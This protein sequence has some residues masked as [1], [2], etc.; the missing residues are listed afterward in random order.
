MKY[1]DI[2]FNL[3]QLMAKTCNKLDKLVYLRKDEDGYYIEYAFLKGTPHDNR[4]LSWYVQGRKEGDRVIN[5]PLQTDIIYYLSDFTCGYEYKNKECVVGEPRKVCLEGYAHD[6]DYK[7][8]KK[9][10]CWDLEPLVKNIDCFCLN[11]NQILDL[12][13][14]TPKQE[15]EFYINSLIKN[16]TPNNF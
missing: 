16:E 15:L 2:D 7:N 1:E 4:C 10:A 12:L 13:I 14:N 5:K 11:Y 8:P 9:C 6:W 3:L